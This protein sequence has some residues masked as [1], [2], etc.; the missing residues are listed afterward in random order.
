MHLPNLPKYRFEKWSLPNIICEICGK[1][2]NLY[3]FDNGIDTCNLITKEL[4]S[5]HYEIAL[6]RK[7]LEK[8]NDIC[9]KSL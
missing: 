1:S 3:R 6:R 9:Q 8:L 7:K 2:G 4:C 5:Y